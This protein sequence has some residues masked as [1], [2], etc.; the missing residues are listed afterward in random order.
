MKPQEAIRLVRNKF[1]FNDYMINTADGVYCDIAETVSRCLR[2][3]DKILD[4]GSGPCNKTAHPRTRKPAK[5]VERL[6]LHTPFGFTDYVRLQ[7]SA[8]VVLSDS[9]T[10]SEESAILGFRAVTLR[11]AG[12][13]VCTSV[14]PDAIIDAVALVL[15]QHARDGRAAR[16]AE[17]QVT[18]CSRR[19]VNFV[20]STVHTP[21]TRANVRL[22]GGHAR[23]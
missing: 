17:Y 4:F 1:P 7:R 14:E 15:D 11:D 20:R 21:H 8:R 5:L 9:G 13:I 16:P 3:G 23:P 18:D 2:P 10:I 6:I 12:S 22:T 19:V